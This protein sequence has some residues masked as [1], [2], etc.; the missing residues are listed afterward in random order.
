M[1]KAHILL[2]YETNCFTNTMENYCYTKKYLS[3]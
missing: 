3:I 2:F 1:N